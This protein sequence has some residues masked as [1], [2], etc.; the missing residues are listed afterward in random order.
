MIYRLHV[1]THST[2]SLWERV[3]LIKA[4]MHFVAFHLFENGTARRERVE[5]RS[6]LHGYREVVLGLWGKEHIY[7]FLWERLVASW[8]SSHFDDVQLRRG[9]KKNKKTVEIHTNK[10]CFLQ[11]TTE[12]SQSPSLQPGL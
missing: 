2:E 10:E 7:C 4:L 12:V 8:W 9:A 6:H 5:L 1:E 11:L 3:S